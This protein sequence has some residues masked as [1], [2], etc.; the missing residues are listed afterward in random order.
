MD[1]NKIYSENFI[2]NI[3][4]TKYLYGRNQCQVQFYKPFSSL[5]LNW[6]MKC[7][8]I[9]LVKC[10]GNSSLFYIFILREISE[11][12]RPSDKHFMVNVAILNQRSRSAK[13]I[14]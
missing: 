11:V 8:L 7:I 13:S 14:F 12:S 6:D 5:Q 2:E 4:P 3:F 10:F 9:G 1:V